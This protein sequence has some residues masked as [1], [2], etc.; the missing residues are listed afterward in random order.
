MTDAF[1][2]EDH[3]I[4]LMR[5]RIAEPRSW[6]QHIPFAYLAID[7]LRPRLLVELG[8]HSGNSY[9]AFCQAV[10]ALGLDTRCVAVDTW[11]GDG[12]SQH[13]GEA[14]YEQLEAYHRPRYSRFSTLLRSLFD[15]ALTEF[16]DGS[17]DLLHIDGFHTYE[18]VKHDFETWLPKLSD[19]AVVL[20]HDVAVKERGFGVGRF[21][22]EI[23][24]RYPAAAFSHGNGLGIVLVGEHV[25]S[26]GRAFVEALRLRHDQVAGFFEALGR[27]IE[28]QSGALDVAPVPADCRLY[29]RAEGEDYG[30]DR[31]ICISRDMASAR[32]L[33]RFRLPDDVRA[34]FVRIDPAEAGGVFGIERLAFIGGD[35]GEGVEEDVAALV[36]AVQGEPLP[37]RPG[38]PVRWLGLR[39]DPSIELRVPEGWRVA[40]GSGDSGEGTRIVELTL[41]YEAVL[42][43]PAGIAM[44]NFIADTLAARRRDHQESLAELGR[45]LPLDIGHLGNLLGDAT[46][47]LSEIERRMPLDVAHLGNLLGDAT[48]RLSEIQRRM[49]LDVA[50]LSNLLGVV[51]A[52]TAASL[53][54]AN[55]MAPRLA[56]TA[57]DAAETAEAIAALHDRVIEESGHL[58]AAVPELKESVATVSTTMGG[59]KSG[60][61]SLSHEL[62]MVSQALHQIT[63]AIESRVEHVARIA[64]QTREDQ[65][66][67]REWV[68]RRRWWRWW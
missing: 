28:D 20:F 41:Q 29:Y 17:I 13:Y 35:G 12:H 1:S 43:D 32:T 45:R 57:S 63:R 48:S 52:A 67:V 39:S 19:R 56:R 2:V 22:E 34:D 38:V 9:L 26:A 64:E 59:L 14:V 65:A 55:E 18:A 3:P 61:E 49:P 62:D 33:Y 53:S 11:K 40:S 24:G 8:T 21:F 54:R 42:D 44:M 25:P 10:E 6:V 15:D 46:S 68:E 47:R 27:R 4:V 58:R 36:A 50:H 30:E 16:E 37:A 66:V 5:P 23:G 60:V 51:E 7:L 31:Q